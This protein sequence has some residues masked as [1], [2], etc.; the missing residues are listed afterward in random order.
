MNKKATTR[1]INAF[2]RNFR[3][4]K[5][6]IFLPREKNM[7]LINRLAYRRHDAI[8]IAKN[9]TVHDYYA[10]PKD[11]FDQERKARGEV[12]WEFK[13]IVEKMPVY[14][15]LQ[16]RKQPAGQAFIISFHA[17]EFREVS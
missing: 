7:T 1:Q 15:K 16:L 8:N 12:V 5:T 9:L 3:H 14:I 11:D 13:T 2:L 4:A 10:G 6:V 17:D